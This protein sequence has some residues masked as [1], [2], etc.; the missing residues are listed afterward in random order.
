[1]GSILTNFINYNDNSFKYEFEYQNKTE[2]IELS[3]Y[4]LHSQ[5]WPL[6]PESTIPTT[7]W[8]HKLDLYIPPSIEYKQVLLYISAGYTADKEGKEKFISPGEN[9]NYTEIAS[10]NKAV[11]AH[12][13]DIPN[14]YLLMNNS[15]KKE[16]EIL[17]YTY[18]LFMEN[19]D[20]YIPGHLPMAKA[21][22]RAMDAIEEIMDQQDFAVDSFILSGP[23]KRGWA[24]WLA[25]IE[26]DRVS[27]LIPIV[28][29]PLN[30]QKSLAHICEVYKDGP[31]LALKDYMNEGII[32]K[33]QSNDF[34]DLVKI[35]DPISYLTN[36]P[37][38][39]YHERFKIPKY[40]INASGD[41]FFAPDC[42]KYYFKDLYG[43]NNYIRY[44]PNSM[45]YLAGNLIADSTDN[46]SKVND[47]VSNYFYF[48]LN[49]TILPKI[50]Y[51][52]QQDYISIN[53][54]YVPESAILW[55][56][57]NEEDRDFRFL[58][59][60]SKWHFIKKYIASFFTSELG[61]RYYQDEKL[62]INCENEEI[63][64]ITATLP[65]FQHGWQASFVELNYN[66]DNH[67]FIITTEVN[68][69]GE[70]V[71]NYNNEFLT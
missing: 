70:E 40:I 59:S 57:N 60:Y 22:I 47:A 50:N 52:L 3:R 66:I 63:C 69:V 31:P 14:Q 12:L 42:S 54:T 64:Q 38:G 39:K 43:E 30:I 21:I 19:K 35:E 61:D 32:D 16:D 36:D 58:S 46:M 45:H 53:S 1:M 37:E 41:D 62:P 65:H 23:S 20:P 4:R 11:V 68:V 15:F 24:A 51:D 5:R 8:V 56:L 34:L 67:E 10:S 29:E 25:A 48:L 18:K 13:Q 28:I 71:A 26:D 9:F 55:S 33:L 6:N 44:L 7:E 27:G 49:K 2:E 17:A